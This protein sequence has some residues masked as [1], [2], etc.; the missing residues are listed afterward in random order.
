MF[1]RDADYSCLVQDGVTAAATSERTVSI[2][3]IGRHSMVPTCSSSEAIGGATWPETAPDTE[4]L[5]D[6]P[7]GYT[8]IATRYCSLWDSTK[9]RWRKPNYS[10]CLHRQL[11]SLFNEVCKLICCL[12]QFLYLCFQ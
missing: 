1:Q 5:L 11:E 4:C 12:F 6:C 10:G 3:V 7:E 8:G 2:K 9:P